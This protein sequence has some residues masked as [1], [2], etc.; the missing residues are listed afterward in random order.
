MLS[1][2][3]FFYVS[4]GVSPKGLGGSRGIEVAFEEET[5]MANVKFC[6][7]DF[8]KY[9]NIVIALEHMR[10]EL[11]KI[12][13][14]YIAVQDMES[15]GVDGLDHIIQDQY[16][17]QTAATEAAILELEQQR[18]I[19]YRTI[20]LAC[21]EIDMRMYTNVYLHIIAGYPM[22][23]IAIRNHC[24]KSTVSRDIKRFF[25]EHK[26]FYDVAVSGRG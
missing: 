19:I 18:D 20:T 22:E 26:K 17:K 7:A 25:R 11:R 23:K 10:N 13:A 5:Y 24:D 3:R 9:R 4:G 1:Q 16:R 14:H 12:K 6:K 2:E 21:G 15:D 8:L